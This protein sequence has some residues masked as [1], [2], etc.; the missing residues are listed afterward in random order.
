MGRAGRV[1]RSMLLMICSE[2]SYRICSKDP[3]AL[4]DPD[5]LHNLGIPSSM[6]MLQLND[7]DDI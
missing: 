6:C 3:S 7:A 5:S 4:K 2:L 1:A